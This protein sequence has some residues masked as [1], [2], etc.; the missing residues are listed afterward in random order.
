M[1]YY[2]PFERDLRG[3]LV[4]SKRGMGF[5]GGGSGEESACQCRRQK[6]PGFDPWIGKIPQRRKWQ[7]TPVFLP[8]KSHGQK[9]LAGCSPQGLKESDTT[10]VTQYLAHVFVKA[11]AK[12][13]ISVAIVSSRDDFSINRKRLCP[14]EDLVLWAFPPSSQKVS[15][16]KRFSHCNSDNRL[17]QADFD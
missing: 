14:G 9:S 12:L 7:S 8:R 17:S 5:P 13:S 10:E 16:T 15:E 6:R 3:L 4:I 1:L 11:G 2:L